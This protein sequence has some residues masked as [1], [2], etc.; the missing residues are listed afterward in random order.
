MRLVF[1]FYAEDR[2]LLPSRT[3]ERAREL[4]ESGYSVRGLF[5]KLTEHAAHHGAAIGSPRSAGEITDAAAGVHRGARERGGVAG[6]GAGA[7]AGDAGGR[8]PRRLRALLPVLPVDQGR[9]LRALGRAATSL[10]TQND[11]AVTIRE[12]ICPKL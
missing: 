4:Y 9:R 8:R 2:D 6:G 12:S 11:E 5:G 1:I 10:I 7:A 3:D